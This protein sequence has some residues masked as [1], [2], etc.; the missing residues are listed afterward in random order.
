M[1]DQEI[2]R[3]TD[4]EIIP[5]IG[6]EATQTVEISDIETVDRENIQTIDQI[7]QDLTTT[8]IKTDHKITHKIGIQTI[9]IDKETILNHLIGKI[10]VIHM[11]I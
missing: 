8:I 6:I 3:T 11:L 1:I 2:H 9:T 7:I 4:V 5:T 10:H